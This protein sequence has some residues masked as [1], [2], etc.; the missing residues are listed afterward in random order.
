MF[1]FSYTKFMS[2]ATA[3]MVHGF[4]THPM[5]RVVIYTVDMKSMVYI[6]SS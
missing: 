3:S 6:M 4:P 2:K 1:C 5:F